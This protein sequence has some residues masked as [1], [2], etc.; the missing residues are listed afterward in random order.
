LRNAAPLR[1]AAT[2]VVARAG[3]FARAAPLTRA[4][5]ARVATERVATARAPRA[6]SAG[7][8]GAALR[9][10]TRRSAGRRG[11]AAVRDGRA[12]FLRAEATSVAARGVRGSPRLRGGTTS[13]RAD[14]S[15][16]PRGRVSTGGRRVRGTHSPR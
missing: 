14:R 8:A 9:P 2:G 12:D 11:A 15:R 6:L 3:A 5:T 16:D 13:P 7:R 1:S 4:L 10:V